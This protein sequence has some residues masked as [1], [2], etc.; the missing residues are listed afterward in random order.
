MLVLT[1]GYSINGMFIGEAQTLVRIDI[2][3]KGVLAELTTEIELTL[4][5]K[6]TFEV[7]RSNKTQAINIAQLHSL[8]FC[9]GYGG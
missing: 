2:L 9:R 3:Q 6:S 5:L 7:K 4:H 1:G 8:Q